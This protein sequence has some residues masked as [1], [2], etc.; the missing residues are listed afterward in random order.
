[1]HVFE[2]Y[3]IPVVLQYCTYTT[4]PNRH[5]GEGPLDSV[6]LVFLQQRSSQEIDI[7]CLNSNKN[8]FLKTSWLQHFT[9]KK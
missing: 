2:T 1:M 3:C 7:M 5:L 9:T 8:A 6:K 4:V